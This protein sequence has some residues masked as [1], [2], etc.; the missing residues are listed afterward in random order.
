MVLNINRVLAEEIPRRS[1]RTIRKFS[2]YP[3]VKLEKSETR[4]KIK[5]NNSIDVTEKI[6]SIHATFF[7]NLIGKMS[8][9][10]IVEIMKLELA[11]V[12]LSPNVSQNFKHPIGYSTTNTSPMIL[13]TTRK[14]FRLFLGDTNSKYLILILSIQKILKHW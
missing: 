6:A 8:N 11:I 3:E 4:K 1:K 12:V 10:T 14:H 5:I 2:C 7:M 13:R 9:V